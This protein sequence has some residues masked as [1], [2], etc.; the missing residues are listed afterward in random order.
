M[1]CLQYPQLERQ[2][3]QEMADLTPVL[4]NLPEKDRGALIEERIAP[5]HRR[6]RESIACLPE[7]KYIPD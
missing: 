2:L 6:M 7:M 1:V 4:K 5:I 3:Q